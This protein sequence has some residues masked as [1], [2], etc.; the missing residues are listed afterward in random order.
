M[1]YT[2]T[3]TKV[4]Y[5]IYV[6][7]KFHGVYKTV[8]AMQVSKRRILRDKMLNPNDIECQMNIEVLR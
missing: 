2:R 6:K 3:A 8:E 7:G 1:N 4:S 5:K